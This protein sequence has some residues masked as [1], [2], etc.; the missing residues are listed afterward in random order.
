MNPIDL[1][2]HTWWTYRAS[3]AGH[4]IYH[5]FNLIEGCF[6]L[7][8]AFL[9]LKR[10]LKHR[11]SLLEI[12]YALAFVTFGL[13]DFCEAYALTTWLILVKGANLLAIVLL[14]QVVLRRYYPGQKAF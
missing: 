3:D 7:L 12:W 11:N 13:S 2:M 14:R 1:L 5:W 10:Y 6:W 8:F 4:A 9:V